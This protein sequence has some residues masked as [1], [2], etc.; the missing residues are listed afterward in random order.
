MARF[1]E[2]IQSEGRS[3]VKLDDFKEELWNTV[4]GSGEPVLMA[5][6][7]DKKARGELVDKMVC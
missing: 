4:V 1:L 2:Q 3:E 6:G 7:L 5:T